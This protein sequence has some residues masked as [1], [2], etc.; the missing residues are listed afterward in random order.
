MEAVALVIPCFNEADRFKGDVVLAYLATHPSVRVCLVDDGSTDGT[1]RILEEIRSANPA[2]VRVVA[3]DTN[4]GKAEAVRRGVRIMAEELPAALI[5]Y[6]DADL[7]TPLDELETLLDVFRKDGAC[8]F[9]MGVRLKRLGSR[10]DRRASRHVLGRIFAT[11]ATF[12]LGLPVYDSQCG[13]K[14]MRADLAPS[15]FDEP[16]TTRWLF[17][18]EILARLRNQVGVEGVLQMVREVPLGRW[19]DV[20]GSKVRVAHMLR[21]PYEFVRIGRR[22]GRGRR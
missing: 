1:R 18:V 17:D 20:P 15:V 3:L 9:A 12:V 5:G 8:R 21:V 6:W 7:S 4:G 16:F 2:Q 13:A 19:S 10:I 14:L 22:Y 11:T